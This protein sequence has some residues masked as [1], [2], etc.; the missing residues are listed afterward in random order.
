M[1]SS[2]QSQATICRLDTRNI[3]FDWTVVYSLLMWRCA[4]IP[5]HKYY[6]DTNLSM[7]EEVG[8]EGELFTSSVLIPS[9]NI[10][11]SISLTISL[12]VHFITHMLH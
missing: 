1:C 12:N 3:V 2:F 11:N 8:G 9:A 10:F 5:L 6:N 7:Y 4:P